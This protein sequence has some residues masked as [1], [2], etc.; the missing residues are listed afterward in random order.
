MIINQ[1][2]F[3]VSAVLLGGLIGIGLLRWRNASRWLR[4]SLAAVYLL[5]VLGMRIGL[6]YRQ[7]ATGTVAD[8]EQ[9]LVDG[10]PTLVYLY[11]N[12]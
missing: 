4:I 5:G 9:T 3:V 10:Q 12:Y 2:S 8:I 11:S 1:Y 6:N 7:Y